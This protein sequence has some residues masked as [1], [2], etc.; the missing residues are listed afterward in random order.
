MKKL[1]IFLLLF[2]TISFIPLLTSCSNTTCT[3][4]FIVND[5]IY[6]TIQVKNGSKIEKPTN[7]TLSNYL[8]E[9]W[10]F[11]DE[12]WSFLNNTV[13][14][15]ITLTADFNYGYTYFGTVVSGINDYGKTLSEIN[16]AEGITE[17]AS[18]AF[19]DSD[20]I[21][22]VTIP[23]TITKIGS[24]A[25]SGC[26]N[27]TYN[28]Y[29]NAHYLGNDDN[30]YAVLINTVSTSITNCTINNDTK[31]IY[32]NAFAN[33]SQLTNITIP[34]N[35][36][37]IGDTAFYYC[38][39]LTNVTILGNIP[40]INLELFR[41]CT[42]LESF[43]IPNSVTTINK[44]SFADN[45]DLTNIVI[46]VSVTNIDLNAFFNCIKLN[47]VYYHGTASD[48]SQISIHATNS[49]L[50]SATKYYY[51]ETQPEN[52]GNYWHYVDGIPTIWE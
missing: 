28:L 29:D 44:S 43:T 10:L 3:V 8:F 2:L 26:A 19:Y 15:D 24:G 52:T 1:K 48:W 30:P 40:N 6:E 18:K 32:S 27:L 4:T 51:S 20:N 33:C 35:V 36:I 34:T 47:I 13:D 21:K 25:F 11:N 22:K 42:N 12:K 9:G 7:P 49:Y 5:T 39:S 41:Y 31:I 50:Q 17:I 45:Y 14:G 37:D 38:S 46:P 16:I 23:S